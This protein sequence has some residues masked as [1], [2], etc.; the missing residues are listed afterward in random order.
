MAEVSEGSICD[1]ACHCCTYPCMFQIGRGEITTGNPDGS[2]QP[3][4]SWNEKLDGNYWM[5]NPSDTG[6]QA[7]YMEWAPS[8]DS[9]PQD[10][11]QPDTADTGCNSTC[12]GTQP[13]PHY[14]AQLNRDYYSSQS[15]AKPGYT[16]YTCPHPL[17]GSGSCNPSVAGIGGYTLGVRPSPPQN[18][19]IQP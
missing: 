12:G 6:D 4:Y 1:Q 13:L 19:M 10:Y 2:L 7:P 17:V 14:F 11:F 8:Q 9:S 3:L 5:V 18:L 16:A 15:T